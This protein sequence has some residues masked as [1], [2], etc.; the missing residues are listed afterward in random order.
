MPPLNLF[1][2]RNELESKDGLVPLS[3]HHNAEYI[4]VTDPLIIVFLL[5]FDALYEP[6]PSIDNL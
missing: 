3:D 1:L 6:L 2:D 5:L 4:N